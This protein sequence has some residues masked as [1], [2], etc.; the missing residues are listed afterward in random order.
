MEG[1]QEEYTKCKKGYL[2]SKGKE[3]EGLCKH[4]K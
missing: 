4:F 1:V 3:I 2:H